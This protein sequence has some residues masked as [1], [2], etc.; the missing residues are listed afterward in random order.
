MDTAQPSVRSYSPA[1]PNGP[2][3][4]S[5]ADMTP[6][7]PGN[8]AAFYG[9]P[10]FVTHI[11]NNA[12]AKLKGYYDAELPRKGTI[13]DFC[14]SWI[15]HYPPD[16]FNLAKKRDEHQSKS[17]AQPGQATVGT[18]GSEDLVVLG[19]GMNQAELKANP[20][21]WQFSVQDLNTDPEVHLPAEQGLQLDASTCVVSI[22]YLTKP[23]DVLS[24]IRQQT[25]QGGTVHLA[26]SNRCFPTKVVGRWLK[27]DE[28]ERLEMVGDYLH[29]AG[30]KE[31][32]IVDVVKTGFF[33]DPLWVVRAKKL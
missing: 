3:P 1:N 13:L 20:I 10:R 8:D 4:Y 18:T 33:T 32:E 15:S 30:W 5:S 17:E 21:L 19:T 22:D 12:I 9:P 25:K 29:W 11:D 14:S 27:I 26:I 2:F 7:D 24:S 31:I 28:Q 6:M 23:V 16:V